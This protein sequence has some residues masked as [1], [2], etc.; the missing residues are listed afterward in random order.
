MELNPTSLKIVSLKFMSKVILVNVKGG[1]WPVDSFFQFS[2]SEV[3]G[4]DIPIP[5]LP[6]SSKFRVL[7]LDLRK[8]E[9][10]A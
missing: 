2:I 5:Q 8:F 4:K 7:D 6:A 1:D 9:F 3:C 10:T